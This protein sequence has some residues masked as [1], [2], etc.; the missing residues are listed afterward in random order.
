MHVIPSFKHWMHLV[1][2]EGAKVAHYTSHLMHERAFWMF[3]GIVALIAA[4]FSLLLLLGN[5]TAVEYRLY[6]YPVP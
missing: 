4:L 6:P 3:L 5:D 2:D 1:H